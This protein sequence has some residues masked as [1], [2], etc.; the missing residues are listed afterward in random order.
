M[1]AIVYNGKE[2][3]LR[4]DYPMPEPK[5]GESLIRVLQSGV[6]STDKEILRGYVPGFRGVMGHEFIGVVEDS[7]NGDLAGKRVAGEINLN[8]GDC[9]YCRTSRPRHCQ[10]RT[11]LGIDGKDGC[12][13]EYLTLPDHL[14]HPVPDILSTETAVLTEPLAAAVEITSKIHIDPEK[15]IAVLGDGRLSLMIAQVLSLTGA[16]LTV[17]GRHE[18]KLELFRP[19]ASVTMKPEGSYEYVVD[20]TG[21]PSGLPLALSLVRKGGVVILKSTYAGKIGRAHV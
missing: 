18:E 20:S 19:Y 10:N 4:T 12:F 5:R 7:G 21:S 2:A 15:N 9:I 13:A 3:E 8:C 16:D 1:K 6:C 17:I 11:V 14:L